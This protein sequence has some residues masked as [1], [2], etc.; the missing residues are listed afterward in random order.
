MQFCSSLCCSTAVLAAA[1]TFAVVSSPVQRDFVPRKAPAIAS[2]PTDFSGVLAPNNA[3]AAVSAI[4]AE[5]ELAGPETVS[6][7]KDSGSL[8][9][10]TDDGYLHRLTVSQDGSKWARE[11]VSG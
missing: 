7:D 3:L 10:C 6:L 8:I 2:S 4:I 5:G 9:A 1:L 11:H